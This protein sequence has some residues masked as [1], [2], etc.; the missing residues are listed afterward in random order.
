MA[1]EMVVK[2][3]DAEIGRLRQA[4]ALLS[5]TGTRGPGRP[6][7]HAAISLASAT[8]TPMRRVLS[9]QARNKIAAAQRKRWA[10]IRAEENGR[11]SV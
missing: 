7:K 1:F 3:I 2:E 9:P 8:G 4:K 11:K 6:A 10:R 5:G